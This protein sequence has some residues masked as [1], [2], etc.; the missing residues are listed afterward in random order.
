M[1]LR[2]VRQFA[3]VVLLALPPAIISAAFQLERRADTPLQPEEVRPATA[4]L[5]GD[6][7]LWVDA[8]SRREF[9]LGHVPGAVRLNREEWDAQIAQFLAAWD[10]DKTVVVYGGADASASAAVAQRLRDELKLETVY[11]MQGGWAA[12]QRK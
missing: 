2:A 7:V 12:W 9:E 8:R 6:H 11:V 3:A 5:W 10:P 1:I 4:R